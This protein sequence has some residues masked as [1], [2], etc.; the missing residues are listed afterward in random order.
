M[1]IAG[2][3]RSGYPLHARWLHAVPQRFKIVAVCDELPGP[4]REAER[5]FGA[6]AYRTHRELLRAGGCDVFVNALPS[7]LHVPA[8]LDA[9]R[10]GCHVVCEKPVAPRAADAE[11]LMAEAKRTGRLLAP[12]HNSRFFPFFRKIRD[13]I[14]S[15]K[16]GELVFVRINW[17]D[18]GRRWDWQTLQRYQGGGLRNA[19][20]H[21]MDHALTLFGDREAPRVFARMS[22]HN[23]FG[24]DA[25]DFANVILYGKRSPTVEV[26]VS[27]YQAY[28]QGGQCDVSG[29]YG[30]LSGG[31]EAVKW[32]YFDP[33][34][35]PK[36]KLMKGWAEKR[37]F[38]HEELPWVEGEWKQPAEAATNPFLYNSRLFY[39][40]FYD[41]FARGG[42]LEVTMEQA[43]R[44]VAAIEECWRQNPL[45]RTEGGTRA[46]RRA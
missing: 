23:P 35:A 45:P 20:S 9:L 28:P 46:G 5:E 3:G 6:V 29:Q 21:L 17:S 2:L 36:R 40:N 4:R 39:E 7:F 38:C 32:K 43:R 41:A 10:A 13:L 12:F 1:G 8:T 14:G 27:R 42:K 24:A 34:R 26:V 33:R 44:Q 15:G 18:F 19:G 16:F 25:D 37:Q 11:R 30:G 22:C 31:V